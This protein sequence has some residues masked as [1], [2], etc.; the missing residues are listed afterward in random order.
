MENLQWLLIIAAFGGGVIGAYIGALP[1]FILTGFIA[2]AGGTAALAG[3]ADLTVGY[4]AFGAY[5]GPHVAFAGG[6]AAAAYA[7]K[8]K[9]LDNGVDITA[10]LWGTGDPM[11]L[12]VGGI[13]GLVGMLIFQVLAAISF[14]SDLPGTTVVILAVVTRFMFGTTGLTGKYE[15]EGNRV[16]FSGGKGFACNV[17]LGLGIGVAI[18]LIY[19]EMVRAGVDAAVLGSF[20]IV[21]F[22]IAAASLIFTQTGFACP[23]THHIAYPAACAAVWSGNPAMGIIFGI[24][25]SLIG[26]F[27]INTFNSHCDT[28]IDPPATTIMILICA[29]TLLFA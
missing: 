3:A 22:G 11:T 14:P 13:F 6:V 17:L 4:V 7:H 2:I 26:D 29:A 20:P 15:G 8:T 16:W 19:A 24:L 1:A 5:L 9:K 18:S 21:C 27:V 28:H 23:A 25:G 12:I 10:S